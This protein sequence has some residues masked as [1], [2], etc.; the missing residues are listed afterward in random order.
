LS[1]SIVVTVVVV[2]VAEWGVREYRIASMGG[3]TTEL[4]HLVVV[5]F[6]VVHFV[7]VVR[8]EGGGG[9]TIIPAVEY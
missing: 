2:V 9:W 4:A 8:H 5:H 6:V 3:D 7:V 1:T